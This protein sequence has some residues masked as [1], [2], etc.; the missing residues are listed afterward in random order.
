MQLGATAFLLKTDG[1]RLIAENSIRAALGPEARIFESQTRL[2][3]SAVQVQ[4]MRE[5]L[6]ALLRLTSKTEGLP[7]DVRNALISADKLVEEL[8]AAVQEN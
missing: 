3:L 4:A 6:V 7:T 8:F 2:P 5:S 1:A